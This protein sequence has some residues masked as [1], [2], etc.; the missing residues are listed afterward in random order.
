M[1]RKHEPLKPHSQECTAKVRDD[2]DFIQC[3][4][5]SKTSKVNYRKWSEQQ[6]I[7]TLISLTESKVHHHD[8]L[9]VCQ[10]VSVNWIFD[11]ALSDSDAVA[12]GSL[13]RHGR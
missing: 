4:T 8:S 1:F 7:K 2:S 10:T 6:A 12:G 9:T 13:R 3:L 11:G 5:N